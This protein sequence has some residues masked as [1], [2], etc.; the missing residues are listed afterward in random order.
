MG[1]LDFLKKARRVGVVTE[2]YPYV[3]IP[4]PAEFRGAPQIDPDKCIG[5]GAC[6]AAC[7]TDSM[8]MVD[9]DGY[10][11]IRIFYGRCIFCYRCED[12]CP[13]D[14]IK[15]TNEFELT[16]DSMGEL[17]YEVHLKMVKCLICGRYFDTER[18]VKKIL[19]GLK[20]EKI[21]EL[22]EFLRIC[23]ECKKSF[24]T[25]LAPLKRRRG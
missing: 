2:K 16:A 23:P 11:I 5:C 10:R 19:E 20:K 7:P 6:V 21:P 4:A 9:K 1:R 14:A 24:Y 8:Q 3:S 17:Y 18:H 13:E 22:E 12:V 25:V 15:R